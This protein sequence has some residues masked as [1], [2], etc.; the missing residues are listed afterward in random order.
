MQTHCLKLAFVILCLTLIVGPTIC[1]VT[2]G[3]GRQRWAGGLILHIPL[4][5]DWRAC[6]KER[7]R[8]KHWRICKEKVGSK[9]WRIQEVHPLPL[10]RLSGAEELD[11]CRPVWQGIFGVQCSK[12]SIEFCIWRRSW[13]REVRVGVLSTTPSWSTW[14]SFDWKTT[15]N[16]I[17]QIFLSIVSLE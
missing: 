11:Y 2:K 5:W 4:C 13:R 17:L 6:W 7:A 12:Q 8:A 15:N 10:G 3:R 16:L 9:L 1:M 14:W